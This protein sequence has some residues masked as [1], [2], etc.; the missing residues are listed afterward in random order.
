L[1]D[2]V[3]AQYAEEA[4]QSLAFAV[5][6]A[7]AVVI[8][9]LGLY[10]LASFA[11]ER[12]TREIGIRKVLGARVRDIV[13]LLV[14]QFSLPVLIANGIAWPVAWYLMSAWLEGFHYRIPEGFILVVSLGAGVVSLLI[15]W[16]T[17]CGRAVSVARANPVLALRYE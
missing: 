1:Q 7:L 9:S 16:L 6:S 15:A 10:G 14:W 5:F 3:H 13:S 2:M 4:R 11:A 12:R 8:A 17:V